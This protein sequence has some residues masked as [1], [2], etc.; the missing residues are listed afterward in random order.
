MVRMTERIGADRDAKEIDANIGH[1]RRRQNRF[2]KKPG[3]L[4][5]AFFPEGRV[6][7]LQLHEKTTS[8]ENRSKAPAFFG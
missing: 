3:F 4:I 1:K 6:V 2:G 5:D 7:P 8:S